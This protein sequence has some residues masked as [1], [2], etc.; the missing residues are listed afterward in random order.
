MEI[1]FVG[2][3]ADTSPACVSMIGSA[4]MEPPPL[5]VVQ[6]CWNAPAVWNADRIRLPDMPHVPENAPAVR[7]SA[8]Y[9]T[10]CLERSSYTIRTSLPLIHEVLCQCCT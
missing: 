8:R 5:F 3:Y 2:M 6:S 9:A 10:A 4:V 7:D 1:T